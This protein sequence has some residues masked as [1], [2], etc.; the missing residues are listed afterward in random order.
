[1]LILVNWQSLPVKGVRDWTH[2]KLDL[3]ESDGHFLAAARFYDGRNHQL[4]SQIWKMNPF[5]RIFERKKEMEFKTHGAT[6]IE[7]F[8][9]VT[10]KHIIFDNLSLVLDIMLS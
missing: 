4:T 3:G 5:T 8:R 1:M 10:L 2:F 9:F 6:D 7:F